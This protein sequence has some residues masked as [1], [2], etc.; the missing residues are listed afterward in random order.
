LPVMMPAAQDATHNAGADA[1]IERQE[2]HHQM[3]AARGQ[4]PIDRRYHCSFG[5]AGTATDAD[6]TTRGR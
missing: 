1:G 6:S 5:P 3:A 4:E 2:I